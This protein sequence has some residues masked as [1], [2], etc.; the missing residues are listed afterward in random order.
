M[1]TLKKMIT[2]LLPRLN[3]S[4]V[5]IIGLI[6]LDVVLCFL[7][8][9]RH[10]RYQQSVYSHREE[11]TLYMHAFDKSLESSAVIGTLELAAELDS[12]GVLEQVKKIKGIG[13]F[14]PQHPCEACM[15]REFDVIQDFQKHSGLDVIIVAPDMRKRDLK[16]YFGTNPHITIIGYDLSKSVYPPLREEEGLVYFISAKEDIEDVFITSKYSEDASSLYLSKY[17]PPQ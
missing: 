14:L 2:M 9:T 5:V 10:K 1:Q 13:L 6:V 11:A 7:L 17:L 15:D 4:K 3:L 12:L 8:V 16:A